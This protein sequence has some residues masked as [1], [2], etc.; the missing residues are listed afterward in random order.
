[1]ATS[2]LRL[3]QNYSGQNIVGSMKINVSITQIINA[4][5]EKILVK[6]N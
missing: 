3:V 6:E 5:I 4:A 2:L 1:M